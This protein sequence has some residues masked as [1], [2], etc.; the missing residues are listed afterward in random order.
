MLIWGIVTALHTQKVCTVI[1]KE[2]VLIVLVSVYA[3]DTA[4]G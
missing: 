2:S 4:G 1:Q 3:E